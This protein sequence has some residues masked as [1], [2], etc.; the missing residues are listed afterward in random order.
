MDPLSA[1]GLASSLVQ[2]ITFTTDVV[3]KGR[4]IQRSASGSSIENADVE[5]IA[6]SLQHQSRRIAAQASG[7]RFASGTNEDLGILCNEVRTIAKDLIDTIDRL[8]TNGQA[9]RWTSLHQALK[10]VWKEK[11]IDDFVHRL[12]LYRRQIDSLLLTH[13][14]QRL[15]RFTE[16]ADD[17][18][19]KVQKNFRKLFEAVAPDKKWQNELLDLVRRTVETPGSG[20]ENLENFSAALSS[21]AMQ[22]RE[23]FIRGRMLESLNFAELR[24]RYETISEAHGRTFDWIFHED[25][26]LD[27]TGD[28][29]DS[30]PIWAKSNKPFYWVTGKPGSGKSTL[31][32]YLSEDPR[33]TRLLKVWER[34]NV[35]YRAKFFLW[36]SG[37]AMQMSRIG[38]MQSLLYQTVSGFPQII[39]HLFPERWGYAKYFGYD[40]R[41][42]N[43]IELSGA[44]RRMVSD[45]T[46]NFFFLIDGLDEFDGDCGELA[47]F[48]LE[49]AM[50][51]PNVRICA[52]SRP[53]LVFED[54][55]QRRPS[56]CMEDL[57]LQDIRI[58][59]AEKLEE[60]PMYSQLQE[61]NPGS[62]QAL[63]HEVTQKSAGVFLWVRLVVKSLLEG[64]R[65]GGTIEDLQARLLLI[66]QGLEELFKKMLSDLD[67]SYFEQASQIFQTVRAANMASG[68]VNLSS[69]VLMRSESDISRQDRDNRSPL[70]LLSLAFSME[71][72]E[73]AFSEKFGEPMDYK[74]RLY[75]AE[76][77]RRRLASRCKG[78][79]EV[80]AFKKSGPEAKVEYLHRT[81]KDF[82]NEA[83]AQ[84][85]LTTAATESV[86]PHVSLCAALIRH[87]K[88]I[89]PTEEDESGR[90]G[91]EGL[92][93]QFIAQCHWIEQQGSGG[94][95]R[96]LNDMNNVV[97]SVLGYDTN[98]AESDTSLPHWTKRVDPYV[99]RTCTVHTLVDY[100]FERRLNHY[101]IAKLEEG[102]T[103][104]TSSGDDFL[105]LVQRAEDTRNQALSELLDSYDT[106]H[107]HSSKQDSQTANLA[108]PSHPKQHPTPTISGTGENSIPKMLPVQEEQSKR[109]FLEG[110]QRL[111]KKFHFHR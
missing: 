97:V 95:V 15:E 31:M 39:P 71:D 73:R 4:E 58:F 82:L 40:Y 14:Q 11:D 101:L 66:P 111:S 99:G 32:K 67:K 55:F 10:S 43:W 68:E 37:S 104:F 17:R 65:D 61:Y 44:I 98:P 60:Y 9:S 109:S 57:T 86:D 49:I 96:F 93:K 83:S 90:E 42:W 7:R 85:F 81:V 26:T 46:R 1:I 54:A 36:N 69:K 5:A 94:Y 106:E 59:A 29:W 76:T 38:L 100:A 21:G 48:L 24:D 16:E 33:L 35:V 34:D 88:A 27:A 30:F 72:S 3:S 8:K 92:L 103:T 22:D 50:E 80:P 18:D 74:K 77:M 23:G 51:R 6:R 87:A 52:S 75:Y 28:D 79:L 25:D 89:H 64:L 45:K 108:L 84:T 20:A 2:L 62:A 53:W 19:A 105:F 47:S 41:P 107:R 78:L 102:S 56:L 70:T 110:V 91:F 12:E 13:L 63:I